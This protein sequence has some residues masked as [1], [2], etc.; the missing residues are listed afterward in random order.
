MVPY[1][2]TILRVMLLAVLLA[3]VTLPASAT[4]EL[5]LFELEGDAVD[6]GGLNSPPPAD[7]NTVNLGNGGGAGART[8][9]L[10]DP[11]PNSIFT[12]GGSK[13]HIDI[14]SWKH[15]AGSVPD[16][17]NITNAYAAAYI[18]NGDLVIYFGAD[19]FANDGDAQLGFWFFQQN[20]TP[21]ADGSFN[22]VHQVGDILVLANFSQGGSVSTI[23]ILEWVGSGGDEGGGTLKLL[24]TAAGAQCGPALGNHDVCAITNAV[25]T[26]SPWP[27]TPKQGSPNVFPEVSFFEGGINITRIFRGATPPCFSSFLAETRSSTSVTAVLKDFVLG[28]FPVCGINITKSC[29]SS[30][31]NDT[32]TGYVYTFSGTVTNTGFGI[33]FNVTVVDDAGTPGNASDDITINLG[34]LA[35]GASAQY[36]GTFESAQNPATNH[37]SVSAATAPGGP[38]TIT[39]VSDPATCPPVTLSPHISVTKVCTTDLAVINNLVAVRVHFVGQVNNTSETLILD[40]VTVRDDSGTPNDPS[41]DQAFNLGT[42]NPGESKPYSGSYLPKG[43]D[44][45]NPK[46]ATFSDTVTA[47]GVARLGFGTVQDTKTA[48]CP[49]CP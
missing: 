28:A 1:Q 30:R 49:L 7:W 44:A 32:Q 11:A 48:T 18:V 41:D 17:D 46:F 6:A 8:G 36:N 23:Q 21:T 13:D 16:K 34:T 9:V 27:Y 26:G 4:D 40:N 10:A 14:S 24:E 15:K 25:P 38:A 29:D 12:G 22:G 37:A 35:G 42:L 45:T 19:R 33:L 39:D 31:A 47:T 5:G 20:V 2:P 43:V 3:F